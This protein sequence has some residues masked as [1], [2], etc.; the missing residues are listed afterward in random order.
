MIWRAAAG[1]RLT[2]KSHRTSQELVKERSEVLRAGLENLLHHQKLREAEAQK[3]NK[4]TSAINPD[5]QAGHVCDA[6][7]QQATVSSQLRENQVP[8]KEATVPWI[9]TSPRS[10]PRPQTTVRSPTQLAEK[11]EQAARERIQPLLDQ[12]QVVGTGSDTLREQ[13]KV[14]DKRDQEEVHRRFAMI[15][16]SDP[17]IWEKG[18]AALRNITSSR[19]PS[20]QPIRLMEP[21]LNVLGTADILLQKPVETGAVSD[22]SIL[23]EDSLTLNDPSHPGESTPGVYLTVPPSMQRSIQKY[24][25][26]HDAFLH[27]VSHKSLGSFSPWTI[28]DSLADELMAEALADVAAEF[29]D[30][31]E[32]YAEAGVPPACPVSHHI[33]IIE[34][35]YK[36][37]RSNDILICFWN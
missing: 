5:H 13:L 36:Q 6:S 25:E 4:T 18:T 27:L 34:T 37:L 28:A 17:L 22:T 31:C 33:N 24:W 10:P 11:A 7:F 14:A 21:V 16:Y 29:Q 30:V 2:G 12:A 19:P 8:Q 26:N 3:P 9:Q 32:E 1:S 20:P 23:D 15:S 35:P